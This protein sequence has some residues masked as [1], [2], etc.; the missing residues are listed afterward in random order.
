MCHLYKWEEE[1][2]KMAGKQETLIY[3]ENENKTEAE[4]MSRSF[5]NT[6]LKNRAYVNALG[7]ELVNKYLASEG[8]DVSENHN[9]H[10]VSK[11]LEILD[12]S[13]ILLPNIHIDVRVVFNEQQIFVPK[14]HFEYN[15]LP[16]IYVVLKLAKDFSNVELLG[17]FEPS[18]INKNNQNSDYYFV[19][20]DLLFPADK[21]IQF[22]K[23]FS[24]NTDRGIS[25]EEML[26]ARQLYISMADHN[27]TEAEQKELIKLM[28]LSN[29]LRDSILEFDNFETLSYSV[30]SQAADRLVK[31]IVP[32]AE[33]ALEEPVEQEELTEEQEE[34]IED[35]QDIEAEEIEESVLEDTITDDVAE[36]DVEPIEEQETDVV[37]TAEDT[38]IEEQ[39]IDVVEE[40]VETEGTDEILEPELDNL[41]LDISLEE[42][43]IGETL[44]EE[45]LE[46]VAEE[47]SEP[48]EDKKENINPLDKI[49]GDVLKKSLETAGGAAAAGA[50][51]ASAAAAGAAVT[52]AA[53]AAAASQEAIKL[54]GVAGELVSEIVNKN[55]ESQNKNLDRIDFDK[56]AVDATEIPEHVAAYD[57]SDA[58]HE[59]NVEAE[60]SGQFDTPKDLSDFET[61]ENKNSIGYGEIVHETVDIGEMESVELEDF[62]ENTDELE[63]LSDITSIDSPTTPVADLEEKLL[64]QEMSEAEHL[65]DLDFNTSSISINEDGTSSLD[66]FNFDVGMP[67]ATADD[68]NLVDFKMGNEIVIDEN[69]ESLDFGSV[70]EPL[71]LDS[72]INYTD[73]EEL[74]PVEE[75]VAEEII[76]ASIEEPVVEEIPSQVEEFVSEDLIAEEP[77]VEDVLSE[78]IVPEE[79]TL[80]M[81]DETSIDDFL[82]ELAGEESFEEQ[83]QEEVAEETP[84]TGEILT[85]EDEII[86]EGLTEEEPI[87]ETVAQ[88]DVSVLDNLED[89]FSELDSTEEVVA[90]DVA[91][92]QVQDEVQTE[93]EW[94]EDTDYDNLQDI[95][96]VQEV[97]EVAAEEDFISEPEQMQEKVFAV[98]EN[99]RVISDRSFTVGEI[100]IDINNPEME[101]FEGSEH[102][103]DLY[104]PD[105]NVP[106]AALLQ[107]PGR[108]GSAGGKGSKVGLGAGLGVIGVILTL[109]IVG[110]IGF[111]VSKMMGNKAEE[112]PQPITDDA[113]PTSPDNGVSDANT[114]NIDQSN[115]VNMDNTQTTPV[116][117]KAQQPQKQQ[118]QTQTQTAAPAA[119]TTKAGP[120]SFL[121]VK[122]LT[123]E[124]PDYIS[125]NSNFKQYFQSAGKSLKLSLTSDLLLANDY[126]Y[127]DQVRVSVTFNKDGSFKEART[128]LS[129]GSKE[130]DNIVLQTVNQ[131][132]KV[133]KAP[134]SVGND[135]ST[136]VILKIY[137]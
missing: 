19:D 48:V 52:E 118:V 103:G 74:V 129:S 27:I 49:I 46:P 125:Y 72:E 82:N 64:E 18:R 14:S 135:E 77:V 61:V 79:K 105:N 109:V 5:I 50:A 25:E 87:D 131:T 24:G 130:I 36:A 69:M 96:P 31:E 84:V 68:E 114:L 13:D 93:E 123:W 17:Y 9:L 124:V 56:N 54:A 1:K 71:S 29:S 43:V 91:A 66:N 104:N 94:L 116:V 40:A 51:A 6:D 134:H 12:I 55:I 98:V 75:P 107:T 136:T 115:V 34:T 80:D 132:L 32:V 81:S 3:I 2:I 22:V 35:V 88:E 59:A 117:P 45:T 28:L 92:S 100:P 41:D 47:K 119:K 95:E 38:V 62:S 106:G 110:V 128:L 57:L 53:G 16:D 63:D 102:L 70:E 30:G 120:T 58:K 90:Q 101:N 4:F 99:S 10:S 39:T 108:L 44:A 97:Q 21:L 133:L 42:E 11:I 20:K 15:I 76:T 78:D 65:S 126:A 122:K 112:A 73:T 7:A 85:S 8:V 121:E 127:T 89:D 33:V 23:D 86:T 137:F 67:N 83:T 111:S 113:L 60:E 37:E 26:R